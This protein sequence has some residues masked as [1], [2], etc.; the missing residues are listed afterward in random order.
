VDLTALTNRLNSFAGFD[1]SAADACGLIN[2]AQRELARRSKYCRKTVTTVG[3][4]VANQGAYDYPDDLILPLRLSV[5]G[6]PWEP[7]DAERVEQYKQGVLVLQTGGGWSADTGAWTAGGVFYDAADDTGTRK[8]NLYPVA[9]TGG[10]AIE[11]EYVYRPQ[12]LSVDAPSAEPVAFPEEFHP[13]LLSYCA[14][15]YY[16]T[17]E[18]NPDLAQVNGAAFDLVVSELVRYRNQR[19]SGNGVFVV[20]IVGQTA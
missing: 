6:L 3:P 16:S 4:T 2:E 15:A 5:A 7:S 9:S 18:D 13:G 10:D 12:D 14:Q 1:L 20:G 11:L 17:V 19:G 8:L